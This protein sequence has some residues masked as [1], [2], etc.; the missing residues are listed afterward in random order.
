MEF[1]SATGWL[2]LP[3]AFRLGAGLMAGVLADAIWL[4]WCGAAMES[5][6]TGGWAAQAPRPANA[7]ANM[8]RPV[9]VMRRA[10]P[11]RLRLSKATRSMMGCCYPGQLQPRGNAVSIICDF[12]RALA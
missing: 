12:R 10:V 3:P 2:G 11:G 9:P 4:M 6:G 1:A 8:T 7:A 5:A